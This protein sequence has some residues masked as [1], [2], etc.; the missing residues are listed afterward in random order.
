MLTRRPQYDDHEGQRP[1]G[2]TST[3]LVKS[4]APATNET[5]HLVGDAASVRAVLAAVIANCSAQ[6]TTG[7]I[8]TF[9]R[10]ASHPEQAVQYYRASSFALTLD[11]YN[12]SAAL[13]S[14]AP[15][16]N[17][18]ALPSM[19]D[20]PLPAYLNGTFLACLNATAAFALPLVDPPKRG[21]SKGAIAGIAVGATVGGIL[22]LL[23]LLF[24]V[25][26]WRRRRAARASASAPAGG[27][28][29]TASGPRTPTSEHTAVHD[30]PHHASA[31]MTKES[32][33]AQSGAMKMPE[34]RT[35]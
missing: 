8:S 1:G 22:L 28:F 31:P 24:G 21:L 7:Q 33:M 18:T 26:A 20:T 5:Y 13:A 2:N 3:A 32:Q 17:A 9:D 15:K 35:S 19:A 25:R 6:D 12:N 11:G 29:D 16:D 4:S 10:A 30:G 23:A 34:P 14:N 27:Q